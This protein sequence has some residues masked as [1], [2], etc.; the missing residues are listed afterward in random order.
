M[1]M[2]TPPANYDPNNPT[3]EP[4]ELKYLRQIRNAVV[5]TAWIV[6]AVVVITLI[7][8]I[9]EAAELHSLV[10]AINNAGFL[11]GQ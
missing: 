1:T 4:Y 11:N 5:T 7:G 10:D 3:G 6:G 9:S 2:T 8:A